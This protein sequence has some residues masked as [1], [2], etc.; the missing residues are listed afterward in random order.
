[1]QRFRLGFRFE[2]VN[3]I[4]VGRPEI[5]LSS[6]WW[7]ARPS[8]SAL[9]RSSKCFFYAV[10]EWGESEYRCC[11]IQVFNF[12]NIKSLLNPGEMREKKPLP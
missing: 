3:S 7:S 5:W 2:F 10:P 8:I 12:C 9:D 11:V 1:M 4:F 6:V